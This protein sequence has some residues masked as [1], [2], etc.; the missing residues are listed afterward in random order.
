MRTSPEIP[1]RKDV[2]QRITDHII[3]DLARGVR[4]W[5]KP[6]NG[7]HAAG[8]ITRPLRANLTPYRGINIVMLWASA[9]DQ[10]FAAPIWM[11]YKQANALGGQVRQG[12]K[13][14][15]VVYANRIT[16]NVTDEETG[17]SVEELALALALEPSHPED[18]ALPQIEVDAEQLRLD[19]ETACFERLRSSCVV[20]RE[21]RGERDLD[22][23][24]DHHRDD[25]VVIERLAGEGAHDRAVAHDAAA[26]AQFLDLGQLVR[27]VDHCRTSLGS[28]ANV[29]ED[30]RGIR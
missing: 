3:A 11:T 24:A 10:G 13:G 16:R 8:R 20:I 1:D 26:A 4:T 30:P 15:L 9:M 7:E 12:A 23:S 28:G 21:P 14:S 6:W 29:A 2:Y 17:E 25:C 18:L 19:R 5:T 27:D 22:R